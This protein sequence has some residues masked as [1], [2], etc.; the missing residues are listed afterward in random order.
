MTKHEEHEQIAVNEVDKVQADLEAK[1]AKKVEKILREKLN[2][3]NCGLKRLSS[4]I[5]VM[6][7]S[8]RSESYVISTNSHT[9]QNCFLLCGLVHGKR[10]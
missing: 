4:M 6:H 5:T 9:P 1:A 2:A 8:T 10:Y 7:I 3:L